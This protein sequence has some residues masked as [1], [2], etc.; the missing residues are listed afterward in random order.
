[1]AKPGQ[2]ASDPAAPT[3]TGTSGK[4]DLL[5]PV[6]RRP[7]AKE[8]VDLAGLVV[9]VFGR[10][11]TLEADG[12]RTLVD[13]GR[14]GAALVD[15]AP[16]QRLTVTGR[17]KMGELKAWALRAEG[18]GRLRVLRKEKRM[19]KAA[20]TPAPA[21]APAPAAAADEAAVSDA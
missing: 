15:V 10:R 19:R 12:A 16:G 7:A 2:T 6:R 17:R 14:R 21:P 5:R 9:D 11:F 18:D 20:Q 1:M 13:L 3:N 8:T 4:K